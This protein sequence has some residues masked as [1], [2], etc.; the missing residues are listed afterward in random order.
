MAKVENYLTPET[1]LLQILQKD[2]TDSDNEM[3]SIVFANSRD[4]VENI[5]EF[6]MENGIPNLPFHSGLDS[7]N[8]YAVL[9]K[10]YDGHCRVIVATNLLSRGIDTINVNH[11]IQYEFA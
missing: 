7:K 11:V 1:L 5:S 10:F 4:E 3:S 8:R 6:L 9:H 2:L